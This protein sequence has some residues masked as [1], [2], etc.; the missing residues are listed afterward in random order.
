MR[1]AAGRRGGAVL[2]QPRP[3]GGYFNFEFNCG[4]SLLCSYIT[5]PTRTADGFVDYVR[6]PPAACERI[7]IFHTMPATVEPEI[8]EITDWQLGFS[9]PRVML[10]E[11]SGVLG[12][13]AGKHWRG[14]FYKCGDETSHPHWAA[15]SPV[16]ELNFHLPRLNRVKLAW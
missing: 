16:D 13:F 6:M 3:D 15:W 4:G 14:N 10:E 1:P 8:T 7:G 11:F 2:V 12:E 5:N 9:I